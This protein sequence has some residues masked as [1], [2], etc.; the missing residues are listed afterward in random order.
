M[1]SSVLLVV[2]ELAFWRRRLLEAASI[3]QNGLTRLGSTDDRID[4]AELCLWA[5]RI[6]VDLHDQARIQRS[7]TELTTHA[8]TVIR[9]RA[10]IDAL[11]RAADTPVSRALNATAHAEVERLEAPIDSSWPAAIDGWS[12]VPDPYAEAIARWRAAESLLDA[13]TDRAAASEHLRAAHAISTR[14]GAIPLGREIAAVAMRARVDLEM[15]EPVRAVVSSGASLGLSKREIEVLVL[16]AQ[17][18]TNRQIANELFITEKTAGHHVSN[19]LSKLG[20]ANRLEAAAIAHRAGLPI[21]EAG[22]QL[23]VLES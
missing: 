19:I 14:L 16:V 22:T 9:L 23:E 6:A 18:R 4:R 17:G 1:V 10:E 5:E 7:T 13:R 2:T 12:D 11:T 8:E 21:P 15:H 20:V 3:A